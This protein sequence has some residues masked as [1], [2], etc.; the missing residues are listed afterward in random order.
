MTSR[1]AMA[2]DC[3]SYFHENSLP[4]DFTTTLLWDPKNHTERSLFCDNTNRVC[5]YGLLQFD[6]NRRARAIYYDKPIKSTPYLDSIFYTI[7]DEALFKKRLA[8]RMLSSKSKNFSNILKNSFRGIRVQ[9]PYY[10]KD[11]FGFSERLRR[12]SYAKFNK[13]YVKNLYW[14]GF[15]PAIYLVK[16]TL[17]TR[18]FSKNT[19]MTFKELLAYQQFRRHPSA[20]NLSIRKNLFI[21]TDMDSFFSY[22]FEDIDAVDHSRFYKI[23]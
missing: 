22:N 23:Y 16:K 7:S 21:G 10:F 11:R 3:K 1:Y 5:Y 15:Y 12:F 2:V 14:H 19:K 4:I 13:S 6:Y 17:N 9:R 8:T 18:F 20:Q